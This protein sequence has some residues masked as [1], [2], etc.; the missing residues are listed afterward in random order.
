MR[1]WLIVTTAVVAPIAL[2][3]LS[4]SGMD[5]TFDWGFLR[6]LFGFALGVACYRLYDAQQR[7]NG[8]LGREAAVIPFRAGA[9]LEVFRRCKLYDYDAH[10]WLG[11]D[12][13][14]TAPPIPV[15]AVAASA[16]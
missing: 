5:T 13:R 12:G 14:P 15:G 3:L 9:L 6:C 1:N 4:K 10:C 7:L 16:C 11:F 8:L 2:L